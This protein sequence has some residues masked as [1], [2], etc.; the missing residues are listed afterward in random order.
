MQLR[1]LG[2]SSKGNCY[3]LIAS[4]QVLIIEAGV[5]LIEVKK[6]LAFRTDN[7]AGCLIS[8]VHNDHAGYIKEY[9]DAGITVLTSDKVIEMKAVSKFC[10]RLRTVYPEHGYQIGSYK[11]IPFE[12]QHDVPCLGFF[13][14]HPESGNIMFITDT[15]M[16]EYTFPDLN[17][18]IIEC[19]YADDIL[20]NNIIYKGLN[21]M[22]RPRL[23]YSHM[24]LE[25]CKNVL[26]S[27]DLTHVINI[28]LI[29]LS[30]GNS[31]EKRFTAEI[32]AEFCKNTLAADKEIDILFDINPY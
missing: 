2:S 13:I 7:I 32:S 9:T 3:L 23:L 6:A 1:V 12:V 15:Y 8:H 20:E 27:L 19:N 16:C 14:S 22:M 4:D 26:R 24:E 10:N 28:V 29:H 21:P 18:V 25:S 11:V 17:H 5:R 30:D 31:D